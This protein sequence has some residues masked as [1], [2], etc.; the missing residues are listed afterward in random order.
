[1]NDDLYNVQMMC[2]SVADPAP[3]LNTKW[4]RCKVAI[5]TGS[6]SA[7]NSACC[8]RCRAARALTRVTLFD[9][10][11]NCANLSFAKLKQERGVCLS[12][13]RD[14]PA[15]LDPGESVSP[16]HF[17]ILDNEAAIVC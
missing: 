13:A 16:P 7:H 5:V 4:F 1:M 12:S 2:R 9:S 17:F 11:S 14:V 10:S 3:Y 6:D 8:P 15:K